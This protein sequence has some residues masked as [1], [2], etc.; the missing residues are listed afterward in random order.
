MFC[1][2]CLELGDT[3]FHG[4]A[5]QETHCF[6][7]A[8]NAFTCQMAPKFTGEISLT[9]DTTQCRYGSVHHIIVEFR[10]YFMEKF[11]GIAHTVFG[12]LKNVYKVNIGFSEQLDTK[13]SSWQLLFLRVIMNIQILLTQCQL[14]FLQ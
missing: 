2:P 1:T 5:T 7:F 6:C 9:D 14:Y 12:S 3:S 8:H 13:Y 10:F 4:N 11:G